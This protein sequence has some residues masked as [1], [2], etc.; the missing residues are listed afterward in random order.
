V[1][2]DRAISVLG[3]RPRSTA[4]AVTATGRSLVDLGLLG[5]PT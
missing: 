5:G 4:D 1:T 3:W 2:A